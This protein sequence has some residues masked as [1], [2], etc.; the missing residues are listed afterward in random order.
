LFADVISKSFQGPATGL[1][2]VFAI[3]NHVDHL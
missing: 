3:R 2:N 1:R